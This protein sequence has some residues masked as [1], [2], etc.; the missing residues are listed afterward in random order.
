ME[1]SLLFVVVTISMIATE[2]LV[3]VS[4]LIAAL[5]ISWI[6]YTVLIL[7]ALDIIF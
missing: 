4:P 7:I 2:N 3:S 1:H 6:I 5:T